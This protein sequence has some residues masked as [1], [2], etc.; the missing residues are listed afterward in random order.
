[1]LK[2]FLFLFVIAS[3]S[4]TANRTIVDLA[5]VTPGLSTLVTALKSGNLVATLSGAGP[6]T[7]FAPTN[8]A[9]AAVP[10][11][12]LASLLD[13]KN[14]KQLQDVLT[15]HV[16]S[17]TVFAKDITNNQMIKT[18]EGK[19]VTASLFAH[20]VFINKAEVITADIKA[21]NGV[22]HII[23]QVLIPATAPVESCN[24]KRDYA[25]SGQV[26]FC[27]ANIVRWCAP[28]TTCDP[29]WSPV[30]GGTNPC[31]VARVFSNLRGSRMVVE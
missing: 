1:M 22:V 19:D 31:V 7:V 24:A 11:A 13:P 10:A 29:S 17:G 21:S 9:F 28:G 4:A 30:R 6:F 3:A 27:Q 26:S 15:Y 25:C 12:T 20:R 14:I 2:S 18:V 23:D 8:E 16:V 5:V